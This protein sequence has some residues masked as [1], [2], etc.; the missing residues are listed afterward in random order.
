MGQ[1]LHLKRL[2]EMRRSARGKSYGHGEAFIE[3][4]R[5][6][7]FARTPPTQE[8]PIY[9]LP[10]QPALYI[11]LRLIFSFPY[12]AWLGLRWCYFL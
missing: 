2:R 3:W 7:E 9:T 4:S 1:D 6:T 11:P 5:K 12:S 10:I 8:P